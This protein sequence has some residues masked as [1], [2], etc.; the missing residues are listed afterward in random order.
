MKAS[1][2]RVMAEW[3]SPDREHLVR[4]SLLLIDLEYQALAKILR[5]RTTKCHHGAKGP[6]S[7]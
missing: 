7:T 2:L 4:N 6:W 1:A 3:F 5:A